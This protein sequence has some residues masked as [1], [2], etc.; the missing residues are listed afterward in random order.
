MRDAALAMTMAERGFD[1]ETGSLAQ[2]PAPDA[3]AITGC[4]GASCG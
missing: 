4:G 2:P 3:V 1:P